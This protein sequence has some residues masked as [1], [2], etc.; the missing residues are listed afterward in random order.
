MQDELPNTG[1]NPIAVYPGTFD[2][3]TN[4][5]VDIIRR[6]AAVFNNIIVAVAVHTHKNTLFDTHE[7]RQMVEAACRDIPGVSVMKF[8]GLLTDFIIEHKASV[9]VRGLRAVSDFEYEFAMALMNKHL[10]DSVET[11]FLATSEGHSF[12]SSSMI[13]EVCKLGGDIS[14]KVPH[15]VMEALHQKF[16]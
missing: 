14:D 6:A 15:R 8:S 4:G 11:V 7:R 12:V 2:P 16:K 5:H 10:S 1:K 3:I 9:I 13:K